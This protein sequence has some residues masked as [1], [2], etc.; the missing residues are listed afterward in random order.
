M[1]ILFFILGL[2]AWISIIAFAK[3]LTQDVTTKR[4]AAR[5][6]TTRKRRNG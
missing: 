1:P 3:Y 2:M 5:K 6:A 4:Q